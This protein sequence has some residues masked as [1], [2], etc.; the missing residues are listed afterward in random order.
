MNLPSLRWLVLPTLT[1][2]ALLAGLF[3]YGYYYVPSQMNYFA[4][5]NFRV[6][7]S[8]SAQVAARIE[9]LADALTNAATKAEAKDDVRKKIK[10]IPNLQLVQPD[11]KHRIQKSQ[12][13][14]IA[15][16]VRQDTSTV[17]LDFTYKGKQP[18][19]QQEVTL[20]ASSD[21]EKLLRPLTSR[22]VFDD[23]FVAQAD[24]RVIYQH[25][26]S[27]FTVTN[28]N[29]LVLS[30]EKPSKL[31]EGNLSTRMEDVRVADTDYKLFLQPI[32]LSLPD[33]DT[34]SATATWIVGGVISADR[35]LSEA[36]EFSSTLMIV[37]IAFGL[38][39]IFSL[40]L[41]KVRYMGPNGRLRI[42]DIFFLAFSLVIGSAVLAVFVLDLYAY[43]NLEE[44]MDRQL[45]DFSESIG[46]N[47]KDEVK[48]LYRQLEV[49][50]QSADAD[51]R[52]LSS[53]ANATLSQTNILNL[54]PAQ[55]VGDP[56]PFFE[57]V[58]WMDGT[59]QQRAKWTVQKET[60]PL[61]NVRDRPYFRRVRED[62]LLFL[63]D[64]NDSLRFWLE[65]LY[66]RSTGENRVVMSVP[67]SKPGLSNW[68]AAIETK[69][70]SL[71]DP[72]IPPGFGY[73]VIDESG[74]VLFHAEAVRNLWENLFEET[75]QDRELRAAVFGRSSDWL[76]A[77]Y[78]GRG[79]RLYASPLE[80]FPWFLV[81]YRDKQ[82]LRT[83][84]LEI[85]TVSMI[86][87]MM[88]ALV[89]LAV[90]GV[91]YLYLSTD[92]LRLAWLWPDPP[93]THTYFMIAMASVFL[94]AVF[95]LAL[96]VLPV[97]AVLLTTFV[98]PV[99]GP[100]LV[101]ALWKWN[102]KN[103][104][105]QTGVR[106]EGSNWFRVG[107]VFAGFSLLILFGVLPA[108]VFFS[109]AADNEL[110]LLVRHG[111]LRL[112]RAFDA[113]A[114]RIA[115]SY[116][117]IQAPDQLVTRRLNDQR[118]VYHQFYFSTEQTDALQEQTASNENRDLPGENNGV[119]SRLDQLFAGIRIP[120][121]QFTVETHGLKQQW[122]Q[123]DEQ[124]RLVLVPREPALYGRSRAPQNVRYLSSTV[125]AWRAPQDALG[126]VLCLG[127]L[128]GVWFMIRWVAQRVFF[129]GV[130]RPPS[131]LGRELSEGP[132][133]R[134]LLLSTLPFSGTTAWLSRPDFRVLDL[135]RLAKP[136]NWAETFN[137]ADL[138]H[139]QETVIAI[140]H[141][142]YRR[143]DA[144][145]NR[146]KLR[147]VE[148]LL[149]LGK[150]IVIAA[151]TDPFEYPLSEEVKALDPAVT[152]RDRE[153]LAQVLS[154]FIAV[155]HH[156]DGG[157][158][159]L[160]NEFEAALS[161]VADG[162]RRAA[163][164]KECGPTAYL[165]RLCMELLRRQEWQKLT[166]DQLIDNIGGQ[167]QG[168][169]RAL[170]FSCAKDEKFVLYHLA[171]DGFVDSKNPEVYELLQKGVLVMDP[172]P[173]LMNESFRRFVV[174]EGSRPEYLAIWKQEERKSSWH[175]L[176]GPLWIILIAVAVFFY[177]TQREVFQSTTALVAALTAAIP[178]A[179]KL[180]DLFARVK[181]NDAPGN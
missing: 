174:S 42:S 76:N 84:N 30:R 86:L 165:Q 52:R 105:Q 47:F 49:A 123:K 74:N 88:Y 124:G 164:E 132:V 92:R 18:G 75:D 173:E 57:M 139:G 71:V 102:E 141:F 11:D 172:D 119:G 54:N 137:Y 106:L 94:G 46:R 87:F 3:V 125:P 130:V 145:V 96:S 62:R 103:K 44:E 138:H 53:S 37:V 32:P 112:A 58:F 117:A 24:G 2:L 108:L 171:A 85:L 127:F 98:I 6:L 136:D 160:K 41:L 70:V 178:A 179:F 69:S 79:H 156:A 26:A 131:L 150:P 59:G 36:K 25:K 38:M 67:V 72:V 55:L 169:Y 19:S 149:A 63:K 15:L 168:Y 100:L 175:A 122:W 134:N 60:T 93:R 9:H 167:A 8:I 89:G 78:E 5:R 120:Y 51:L 109:T 80:P 45:H 153:R 166:A 148:E 23:L 113:R 14:D 107:Y 115:A 176:Q 162:R 111:Q 135:R 116:R 157:S 13:T 104:E 34:R 140:D 31:V 33:K 66:T 180:F 155:R 143:E 163:L 144:P 114:E 77:R 159:E 99:M 121:N 82:I 28:L 177:T 27:G 17:R 35:Y 22:G 65:P 101:Y 64:G 83:T 4:G 40:P 68:V 91:L 129:L 128:T 95:G 97:G 1:I 158:G 7:S 151:T 43:R 81:V 147:F 29:D 133:T 170:W 39:V 110:D 73:A 146:Q 12:R 181:S 142:D 161:A 56:Y 48:T 118:D 126:L 61:M 20:V 90:A 21:L 50:N 152:A 154:T 10:L 16:S